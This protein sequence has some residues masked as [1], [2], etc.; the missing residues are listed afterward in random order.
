[1]SVS[2]MH[3]SFL[4]MVTRVAIQNWT[5][6][7]VMPVAP[8]YADFGIEIGQ[9]IIRQ[10]SL[11]QIYIGMLFYAAVENICFFL[12]STALSYLSHVFRSSTF[13]FGERNQTV[14]FF[15]VVVFSF[16]VPPPSP[17]PI[18]PSYSTVLQECIAVQDEILQVSLRK[19][20]CFF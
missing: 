9:H 2:S 17:P 20:Q 8:L 14:G 13:Y 15:G 7:V 10:L 19:T 4:Q 18:Q 5:Q 11:M 12:K 6:I 3:L 16:F 1:M